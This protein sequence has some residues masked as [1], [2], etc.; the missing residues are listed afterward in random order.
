MKLIIFL[1]INIFATINSQEENNTLGDAVADY[2]EDAGETVGETV[3]ELGDQARN[4]ELQTTDYDYYVQVSTY[5]SYDGSLNASGTVNITVNED[6]SIFVAFDFLGLPSTASGEWAIHRGFSCSDAD[7]VGDVLSPVNNE[8]LK[9]S[10]WAS[11]GE[12]RAT[13]NFTLTAFSEEEIDKRAFVV[14]FETDR[15]GC[16]EIKEVD[17]KKRTL[18]FIKNNV[19]PNALLFGVIG[20]LSFLVCCIAGCCIYRACRPKSKVYTEE[21]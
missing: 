9:D 15:V 10:F 5:P 18:N 2:A 16:G 17:F 13:G 19:A 1:L 8:A 7:E 4:F 6:D 3:D 21:D 11:N 14:Y 12:G 20:G